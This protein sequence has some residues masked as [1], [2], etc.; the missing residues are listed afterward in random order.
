MLS[1][2]KKLSPA[3][4]ADAATSE[5]LASVLID[6]FSAESKLDA[7]SAGVEPIVK[8]PA[9]AGEVLVAVSETVWVVPSGRL[10]VRLTLSPG[11]G[12]VAPKSTEIA[13]GEPDGP[14]TVA[15]V[16]DEDTEFSLRPKGEPATSS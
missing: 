7:V 11:F 5:V 9:G 2:L 1:V 4:T 12:L 10:K 6:E 16:S 14:E 15:P 8:L 3:S 13:A